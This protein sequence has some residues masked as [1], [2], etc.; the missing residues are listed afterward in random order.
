MAD[1]IALR[2]IP[3][4]CTRSS[5][6]WKTR[7]KKAAPILALEGMDDRVKHRVRDALSD[8]LGIE[9]YDLILIIESRA[10]FH[11]S[12]EP[13]LGSMRFGRSGRDREAIVVNSLAVGRGNRRCRRVDALSIGLIAR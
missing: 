9:V 10:P 3:Q 4:E 12:A 8:D 13:C 5:R 2:R 7:I 1:G 6:T 11:G